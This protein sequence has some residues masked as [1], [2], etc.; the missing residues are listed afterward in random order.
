[1]AAYDI[2]ENR[3]QEAIRALKLKAAICD[4]LETKSRRS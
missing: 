2:M 3:E 4:T 1:T